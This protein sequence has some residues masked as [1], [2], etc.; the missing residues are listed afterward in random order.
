MVE[1]LWD[2]ITQFVSPE[3]G[4]ARSRA[5]NESIGY[6]IPPEMRGLL[7]LVADATPSAAYGRAAQASQE[8][9]APGRTPM[10]RIGSAGEMLSSTAE[11]AAPMA[12]A[13]RAGM[14]V[15]QAVQ[16]GLLGFSAGADDAARMFMA[17]E[18]GALTV[19]PLI[20]HHNLSPRGVQV[21]SEIGGIPM[22]SMA[23]SRADYPLTNFGDISLLADP[24][25]VSPSRTV[26]AW[27][28]DVYTGRQPRG[29]LQFANQKTATA[30][31]KS[32]PAFGHMRDITY[33]MDATNSFGDANEMMKTAQLGAQSGIDPKAYDNMFDYVR[34]VRS[35]LGYSAYEN[36]ERMPGFEAYG[37]IDRVLY[38]SELFTPSGNR[39]RPSPYTLDTVMKRMSADRAYTAGSEGWD[40]GPGSFRAVV[41]P[42]FRSMSQ[43]QAARERIL[44]QD[45]MEPIKSAFSDAYDAVLADVNKAYTGRGWA[46]GPEAMREIVAGKTPTWFGDI[47]Q[48]TRSSVL[49]LADAAR[50]LPTEYFEAKPRAAYGLGDFPAALVPE[51]DDAS[52]SA[53]RAAGVRDVLTYGSPEERLAFFKRFPALLFS[54]GLAAPMTGL[55]ASE[56]EQGEQY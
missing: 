42:P 43:M 26:T 19:A 46:E 23:V 31:M 50:T 20:G 33:W 24:S 39:K 9:V 48:Q 45:Q 10:Q 25:M 7:G 44:P 35:R 56:P 32:D 54:M 17:D 14:P 53:L 41:T 13:G 51:G 40:Y 15:A 37:E 47:P 8:M 3:A 2:K 21:A 18:A 27:P 38:P 22:P 29:E 11:I 55:L 4:Q 6:Y 16:E 28:T 34:D 1:T 12:V 49:E 52:V 36:A 30:A 5:L